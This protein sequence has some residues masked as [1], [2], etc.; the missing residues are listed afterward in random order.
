M[1]AMLLV[2]AAMLALIFGA[3][4]IARAIELWWDKVDRWLR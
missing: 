4:F 3:P 1:K 2:M